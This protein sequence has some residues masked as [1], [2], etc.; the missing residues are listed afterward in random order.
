MDVYNNGDFDVPN[1][2]FYFM[3]RGQTDYNLENRCCAKLNDVTI[4]NDI[5]VPN[6]P[7][8]IASPFLFTTYSYYYILQD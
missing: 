1:K 4:T 3:R 2:P 7:N 5:D 8:F 6:N